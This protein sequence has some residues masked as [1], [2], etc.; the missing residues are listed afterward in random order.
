M[1]VSFGI[2]LILLCSR[3]WNGKT[4]YNLYVLKG[5]AFPCF[6]VWCLSA[7]RVFICQISIVARLRYV[8]ILIF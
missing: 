3:I 7:I 8:N 4:W 1:N 6:F 2:A 5:T